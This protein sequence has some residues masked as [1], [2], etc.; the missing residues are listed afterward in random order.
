M[1]PHKAHVADGAIHAYHLADAGENAESRPDYWLAVAPDRRRYLPVRFGAFLYREPATAPG[2]SLIIEPQP[3]PR[4][5]RLVIAHLGFEWPDDPSR[6]VRAVD[7]KA[8]QWQLNSWTRHAASAIMPRAQYDPKIG[9]TLLYYPHEQTDRTVVAALAEGYRLL[10]K[11][12][13]T[14]VPRTTANTSRIYNQEM[15]DAAAEKRAAHPKRAVADEYGCSEATAT[16]LI[17]AATAAG[18]LPPPVK[19]RADRLRGRPIARP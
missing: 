12:I 17:R 10:S 15:A 6:T 4:G 8:R 19:R 1:T 5:A 14:D 11:R 3:G 13:P 2:V 16:R 9:K 7:F 18:A